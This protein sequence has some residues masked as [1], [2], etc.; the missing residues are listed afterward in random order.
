MKKR[1]GLRPGAGRPPILD[2]FDRMLVGS[3]CQSLSKELVQKKRQSAFYEVMEAETDLAY[4]WAWANEI[5]PR[6]RAS[7]SRSDEAREHFDCIA[8]AREA[9]QEQLKKRRPI[10]GRKGTRLEVLRI[11]SEALSEHLN[12]KITISFVNDCWKQYNAA[13]RED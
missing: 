9:I 4:D 8:D 7:W 5:P 12:R 11:I 10:T 3:N 13:M 6:L 1:G 2:G